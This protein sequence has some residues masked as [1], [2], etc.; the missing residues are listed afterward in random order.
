MAITRATCATGFAMF[1]TISLAGCPS[2]P[3]TPTDPPPA[4]TR[5][6]PAA[7]AGSDADAASGPWK[8]YPDYPGAD[9]FCGGHVSG[10]PGMGH[11]EWDAYASNDEPDAVLAWYRARLGADD[12]GIWRRPADVPEFVLSVNPIDA[13]GPHT[14]C[15]ASKGTKT[16]IGASQ[17]IR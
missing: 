6:E 1:L 2:G 17:M 4:A 15:K 9:R 5:S 8:G 3:K 13:P 11:I 10:S 14:E 12:A 7:P 16:V